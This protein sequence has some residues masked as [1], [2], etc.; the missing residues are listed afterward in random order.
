MKNPVGWFEIYVDDMDKAKAF[1][2]NVLKIELTAIS[3]PGSEDAGLEMWQFPQSF[4]DYGAA[5][6]ICRMNG[7]SP[8]GT[9]TT[10][11][12]SCNDCAIEEKRVKEFGGQVLKSKFS[13]GEH[14]YIVMCKDPAGNMI[15]LHSMQ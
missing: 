13:I 8:G 5:G 14:G 11:Y 1:Y 7:M 3:P 15:G 4:S 10:V 6:A 12:F 2:Q 9:G